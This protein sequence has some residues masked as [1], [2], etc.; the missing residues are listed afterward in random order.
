MDSRS[1]TAREAGYCIQEIVF[2]HS[3]YGF[4]SFGSSAEGKQDLSS[5]AVK[6]VNVV[7][8]MTAKQQFR[9]LH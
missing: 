2:C 6:E 7:Q 4:G 5:G 9:H 3:N 8:N 1:L